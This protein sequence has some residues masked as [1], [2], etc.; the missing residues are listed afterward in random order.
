MV[1]C[2]KPVPV[3]GWRR[4]LVLRLRPA[5]LNARVDFRTNA[6]VLGM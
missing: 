4:S 6:L 1:T 5:E 3:T 2:R